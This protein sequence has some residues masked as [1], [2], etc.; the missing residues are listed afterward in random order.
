[1]AIA[2]IPV[3]AIRKISSLWPL[4]LLGTVLVIFGIFVVFGLEVDGLVDSSERELRWM[5][6]DLLVCMGQ[7]WEQQQM[8]AKPH[9]CQVVISCDWFLNNLP[10]STRLAS[11]SKALA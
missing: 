5:N 10:D 11:C 1:M 3:V 6:T 9:P 2:I 7:A 8:I 4:S